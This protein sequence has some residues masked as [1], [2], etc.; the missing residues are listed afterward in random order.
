[1]QSLFYRPKTEFRRTKEIQQPLTGNSSV[2]PSFLVLCAFEV[3][4]ESN[5]VE[6]GVDERRAT[7]LRQFEVEI[8]KTGA[9]IRRH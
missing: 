5:L 3:S 7:R 6:Q 1:M 4:V 2:I 8:K 9:S